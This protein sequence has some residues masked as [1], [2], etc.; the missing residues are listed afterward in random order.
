MQKKRIGVLRG[1]PSSEYEVSLKTGASI[2]KHLPSERYEGKDILIDRSGVWHLRGLPIEPRRAL[3]QVDVVINGLHGTY[4]ED[5]T[6]QKILQM[7]NVPYTGSD[8]LSSG[9]A[10]NKVMTKT[11]AAAAGLTL[12]NQIVLSM[13]RD[14]E[15]SLSDVYKMLSPPIVIKP[16][17]G[18]SS[19]GTTVART[20]DQF[21][22]GVPAAFAH[23]N[24]VL[25]EEFVFGKEATCG[26]IDD[27]RGE[28]VYALPPI[29]IRPPKNSPFFDYDAKYTGVT[30]EICPGN[31]TAS[32]K[33][34][35]EEAAKA[36][37]R[38][39]GLRHYSRSDFIVS[40]KGIYF[41]EVNTLPGMTSESLLPKAL[42]AVGCRY[43]DFL[44]HLV[45]LAERSN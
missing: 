31:F 27:F 9:I 21:L 43:P 15:I 30:Q 3:S 2:L 45:G 11:R 25:L 36:I 38:E 24:T 37:H 1:G 40:K 6:V 13:P 44:E 42:A 32:E 34:A 41:L 5:G 7:H 26:V 35:I 17:D 28:E 20:F 22:A 23:S 29:E 4:G 39:I 18:G 16:A 19:V 8:A 10:M 33:R 14:E 12:A